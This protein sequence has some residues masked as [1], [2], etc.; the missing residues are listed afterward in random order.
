[1]R[2]QNTLSE[3]PFTFSKINFYNSCLIKVA[4]VTETQ[5]V[6]ADLYIWGLPDELHRATSR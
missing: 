3:S 4:G 2:G 5:G 6:Q 1:M